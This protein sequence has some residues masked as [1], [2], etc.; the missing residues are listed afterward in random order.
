M[1]ED[2]L[3]RSPKVAL[4]AKLRIA[5]WILTAVVLGLVVVM[6][7]V[8]V[9][10]P[11]GVDFTFLPPI[12]AGLNTLVACLL[13]AAL[14]AIKQKRVPL[15][16]Q[17]IN[18]AMLT[19][20]VFLLCYVLYHITTPHT[21]YPEDAP[22]RGLYLLLLASHIILAALSLP[23]ILL[24]WV[25]GVTNHFQLHKKWVKWVYPMWL[26]VAITGPLCYWMLRPYYS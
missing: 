6:Q 22:N 19:S 13:V 17:C 5:I 9:P 20:I 7:Y 15:H 24:A 23:Y 10:L 21:T 1:M 14:V 12:N 26:Y 3:N 11:E 18:A 2:Y 16:V 25:Y 8:K 4:A